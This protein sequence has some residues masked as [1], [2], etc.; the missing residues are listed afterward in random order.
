MLNNF[1]LKGIT[2]QGSPGLKGDRGETV[3]PS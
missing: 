2:G 1:S 3:S